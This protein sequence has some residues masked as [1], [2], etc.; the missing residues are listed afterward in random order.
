MVCLPAY[1]L[2]GAGVPMELNH[3]IMTFLLHP[4]TNLR[5]YVQ[6]Q[7]EYILGKLDQ[8]VQKLERIG[9]RQWPHDEEFQYL[10]SAHILSRMAIRVRRKKDAC[11]VVVTMWT[12]RYPFPGRARDVVRTS[13]CPDYMCELKIWFRHEWNVYFLRKPRL[14][15]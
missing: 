15:D 13:T 2:L 3:H 8:T 4:V 11:A 7:R 5:H 1:V 10:A 9:S 12:N 6:A 14:R